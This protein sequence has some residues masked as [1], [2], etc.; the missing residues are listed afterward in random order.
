MDFEPRFGFAWSPKFWDWLETKSAVIRGGYGISHSPLTGNNRLPNPDFGGF[1]GVSTLANGS[2][3]GG[4]QFSSQ[5]VRLTGNVPFVGGGTFE[6]ALTNNFG[7]NSDGLITLNSLGVPG[8]SYPGLDS[9]AVPYT[10]N[11]NVSFSMELMKNMAVEFAYVGNKGTHLFMPFVNENPRD[12][13]FVE[14]LEGSNIPA[15]NTFAD[16]LGRRNALGA[17]IAIQ[18]NSVT[19][20]YFGFNT[21]N[22]F[23]DSSAN[24]IRH[25]GYVEL[26]KRFSDGLSF[27]ANYT[28]G[29][30][31]DDASDSSPDVRVLTTGSTLG[32][33]F[34]GAPRSGDRSISSFD[35][36]HNFS[37]TFVWDLPIG[38]TRWL[39]KDAHPAVDAVVG[40]W[41][42]SGIFRLMGGQPFTPFI[43][44]TNRLGGTN[45][46]VR[47]NIVPGVPLLN[48]LWDR[49][50]PM[51]AGCEPYINPA[52]FMRPPKGS[53]GN[54]SR[55]IDVRAPTQQLFDLSVQKTWNLPWIG[56]EGK[57]KINFRVD[58][59]NAL[60][61]PT[62]RYN[63][64]GN[65]PFG[66][67]TLPTE[68]PITLAEYNS[69]A[70]FN[71]LPNAT[72]AADPNLVAVQN[73]TI[74]N[75]LPSGAIPL[76]FYRIQVPVG[77][78]TR[79]PN[80]VVIRTVVGMKLYRLRG[81]Y[82]ANFGT[83]F[84]V[85]NPRY[86]QFGVRVFF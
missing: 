83:L 58:L 85:N 63:N 67:G 39:L 66:F 8:F 26:R 1:Q 61:H 36:K 64:T 82:D 75:R 18:R 30:S 21:L 79:V 44:D 5:P 77:F 53:L 52:A 55:T 35:I 72:G 38:R 41:S 13:S 48:P 68:T 33:V 14:L 40:G 54:S 2:N 29:K 51:G 34:Y 24:S 60:N 69:W 19:S 45:R 25:A 42:M 78:A 65:T 15:E 84:A 80:S 70:A 17:V 32:Q 71:G 49:D 43:T 12:T 7:L 16:P 57:R 9:G 81:T 74:N 6:Q 50:C 31:I 56:G 20:P 76:N 10:Q 59:L 11:W 46:S 86:I 62:F 3:V 27:T 4:T 23:F 28:Y 22:R 73:L 37:S 47:L